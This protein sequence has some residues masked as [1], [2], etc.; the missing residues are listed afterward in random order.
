[1]T[2][3][4]LWAQYAAA[5]LSGMLANEYSQSSQQA[6]VVDADTAANYADAML[7]EHLHRFPQD[8]QDQQETQQSD[9]DGWIKWSGGKCPV[10]DGAIVDVELRDGERFSDVDGSTLDWSHN[11]DLHPSEEVVSYRLSR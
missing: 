11:H 4:Q 10:D 3:E 5:A 7:A 6:M 9:A 2:R 1:M 8:Q